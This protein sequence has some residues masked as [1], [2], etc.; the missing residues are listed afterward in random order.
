MADIIDAM[1]ADTYRYTE[2]GTNIAGRMRQWKPTHLSKEI[3][4]NRPDLWEA[5]EESGKAKRFKAK[6]ALGIA[7]GLFT[8][9]AMAFKAIN[10]SKFNT[11]T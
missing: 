1:I 2:T 5:F 8:I 10:D 4:C 7:L 6:N 11:I 3:D 9:G